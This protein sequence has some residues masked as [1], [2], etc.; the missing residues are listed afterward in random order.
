M[1]RTPF[2]FAAV[3]FFC[4]FP[5]LGEQI[6]YEFSGT[7]QPGGVIVEG[8]IT[9]DPTMVA[10]A[11]PM[12]GG[13]QWIFYPGGIVIHVTSGPFGEF[14]LQ[15]DGS[16]FGWSYLY[17][18][19]NYNSRD[20]LAFEV[21]R[22]SPSPESMS[23]KLSGPAGWLPQDWALADPVDF[24]G[25]S[26]E[27]SSI[28]GWYFTVDWFRSPGTPELTV[29]PYPL[30]DFG[31]VPL[32]D[33]VTTLVTVTNTGSGPLTIDSI[34][35]QAGSASD[36]LLGDVPILPVTIPPVSEDP[37]NG[38]VEVEVSF[39]PMADGFASANLE[40]TSNDPGSPMV[41]LVLTGTGTA[42]AR[43]PIEQIE[44]I[45]DFVSD[46]VAEGTLLG[47]GP[48][49]SAPGRVTAFENMLKAAS[50]LISEGDTT[51]ACRQLTDAYRKVDGLD[52]PPD[53]FSSESPAAADLADLIVALMTDLECPQID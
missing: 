41:S 17:F 47:S 42:V 31:D 8:T 12:I 11:D 20:L 37:V 19:A 35:F 13:R 14:V 18:Q 30:Y 25:P 39:A 5:V 2:V 9:Y 36:F 29:S 45:I 49:K 34:G 26:L 51:G 48:G 6:V 24:E 50:D 27:A 16:G 22:L 23:I 53:F 40:I 38:F 43:P 33:I 10:D 44:D 52:R 1:R 46:A 4:S 3:L 21:G 7:H 15:D 28:A 32:G